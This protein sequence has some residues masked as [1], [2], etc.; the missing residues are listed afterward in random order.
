MNISF[1]NKRNT[2]FVVVVSSSILIF[3]CVWENVWGKKGGSYYF[4]KICTCTI[5]VAKTE[6]EF[7]FAKKKKSVNK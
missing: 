2:L 6:L 7:Y 4:M 3:I 1:H 5:S